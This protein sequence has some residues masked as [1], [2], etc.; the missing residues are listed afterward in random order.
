MTLWP[1]VD[2]FWTVSLL[3][4]NLNCYYTTSF[5]SATRVKWLLILRYIFSI[6]VSSIRTLLPNCLLNMVCSPLSSSFST[7]LI[8][9]SIFL[10]L[11]CWFELSGNCLKNSYILLKVAILILSVWIIYF[12][13]ASSPYSFNFSLSSDLKWLSSFSNLQPYA[14]G[15]R[16]NDFSESQVEIKAKQ[17]FIL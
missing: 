11:I 12:S 16:S 8:L 4:A 10:S 15:S 2:I 9:S 3:T 6:S 14:L 5:K 1:T 17:L 13:S 7:P